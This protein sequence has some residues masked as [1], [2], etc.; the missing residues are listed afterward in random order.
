VRYAERR[1]VW[2]PPSRVPLHKSTGCACTTGLK[3]WLDIPCHT[4]QERAILLSKAPRS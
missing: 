4:T 2:R 1:S 3:R